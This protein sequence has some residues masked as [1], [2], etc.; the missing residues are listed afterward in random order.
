VS[1]RRREPSVV[2]IG[3]MGVG[4][5]VVGQALARRLG[6]TF[7]DTDDLVVDAA[8][9]S[10]TEIFDHQGEATFRRLE[11]EAVKSALSQG[12]GIVATGG[13][14]PMDAGSWARMRNGN[15][16]VTL[17]VTDEER[18]WRLREDS[19]RPLRARGEAALRKLSRERAARY[20]GAHLVV[21][22]SYRTVDEVVDAIETWLR[23]RS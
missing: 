10:I 7:V 2:L 19:A 4:K 5:T 8:G 20:R 9:R 3:F 16:V 1:A 6:T 15:R 14:A 23:S 21:D 11:R 12:G 22:T 13:G 17:T 18:R